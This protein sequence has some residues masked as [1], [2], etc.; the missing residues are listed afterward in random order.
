VITSKRGARA[1]SMRSV[2]GS[3]QEVPLPAELLAPETTEKI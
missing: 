1:Y 3:V 2:H